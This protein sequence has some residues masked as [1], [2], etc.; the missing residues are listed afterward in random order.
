MHA[1][2]STLVRSGLLASTLDWSPGSVSR[3]VDLVV[4]CVVV[5]S[6]TTATATLPT[7]GAGLPAAIA[8]PLL[9]LC[10]ATARNGWCF[11]R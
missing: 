5:L 3:I 10:G 11:F 8:V 6:A 2:T 7:S 1:F 9:E 4:G